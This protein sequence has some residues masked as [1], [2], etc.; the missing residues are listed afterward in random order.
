[1]AVD[2]SPLPSVTAPHAS[3]IPSVASLLSQLQQ[4]IP[5]PGP[6]PSIP[7]SDTRPTVPAPTFTPDQ[8]PPPRDPKTLSYVQSL[9]YLARLSGDAP[10]IA[11]LQQ[12]KQE[13]DELE[14]RL[15]GE[16]EGIRRK[17]DEKVRVAKTRA[18]MIGAGISAHEAEMMQRAY[19]KEL[20]SFDRERVL[21]AWGALVA[22]QQMALEKR[23][24]PAMF[25]TSAPADLQRQ[26]RVVSILEN[27]M[28]E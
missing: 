18:T 19:R 21:I 22:S 23:T 1:M 27:M 6:P 15:H 5:S 4:P 25:A 20:D 16:R 3:A 12:L 14:R 28:S 11:F 24:V 9:G 2:P 10:F 13:Q 26:K 17:Y 7:K 8:D